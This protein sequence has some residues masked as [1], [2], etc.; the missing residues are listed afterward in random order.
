M[1]KEKL[2]LTASVPSTRL[3]REGELAE[4]HHIFALAFSTQAGRPIEM[5]GE[6]KLIEPRWRTDPESVLVAELDG[7]VVG[8]NVATIWGRFGWFGPLTV[9]PDYWNRGIAQALMVPTMQRFAKHGTTTERLFTLPS[10][11]KH[12]ALYQRYGFWPRRLTASLA[13]P[14][15]AAA[16][17]AFEA[18]STL[19][20]PAQATVLA[21]I[22]ALCTGIIDG[23]DPTAEVT[24][25]AA[26]HL[27]E[28]VVLRAPDGGVDAFAICHH[29]ASSEAGSKNMSVKFG[30]A[31]GAAAYGRLLDAVLAY[32]AAVNAEAVSLAVNAAREGAYRATL[33]RGFRIAMLGVAM[34]RGD[35]GDDP[36]AWLI[37][38]YR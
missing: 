24:A 2:N 16:A 30:A 28:T 38:D 5:F 6:R 20:E 25:V 22:R 17:A 8:S 21:R 35:A 10:S 13:R 29:G 11:P 31:T 36:G 9:H 32:G 23:L 15:D 18:F 34:V 26:Q 37:E 12:I 3:A 14:P 27:G 1:M 19:G 4:L 7:R 33:E